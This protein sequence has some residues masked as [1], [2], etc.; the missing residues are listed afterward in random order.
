M[1]IIFI[2]TKKVILLFI[3]T[4]IIF[5]NLAYSKTATSDHGSNTPLRIGLLPH[6]STG[7]LM[8]LYNPLI[9][10]LKLTL[11]RPVIVNTAP[12]FSTYIKRAAQ[13]EYD[14]YHTAPHMAALAEND[15]N[16]RRIS[17]FGIELFSV[18]LVAKDS[19]YKKIED[20]RGKTFITPDQLAIT[21]LLGEL[22][23]KEH[24]LS[25]KNDLVIKRAQ[26]HNNA[27][28]SI[29]RGRS[30][31]GVA[32]Y[33]VYKNLKP[34]VR[35]KLRILAKTHEVPHMMFMANPALSDEEYSALKQSMLN[36]NVSGAGKFFFSK[37]VFGNMIPIVDNDMKRLQPML[38]ILRERM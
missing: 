5:C 25:V 13:G 4:T 29:A 27:M 35:D 18:I 11:N 33:A 26:S 19:P 38:T 12:N 22:T 32:G 37:T 28:I 31:A 24:G 23:L 14:L 16:F 34:N 7:A 9:E 1:K 17:R 6:L 20:L 30:E 36:F 15:D 10:H 21:T 8:K 2:L 3:L